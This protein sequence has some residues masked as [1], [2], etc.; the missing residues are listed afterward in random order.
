MEHAVEKIETVDPAMLKGISVKIKEVEDVGLVYFVE[1]PI[2]GVIITFIIKEDSVMNQPEISYKVEKALEDLPN[3]RYR[4]YSF[5]YAQEELEKGNLYFIKNCGLGRLIYNSSTSEKTLC[6]KKEKIELLL[7]KATSYLE[8]EID[9]INSFTEGISFYRKRKEWAGAAFLIHQKIEWLYRCL[10]TFAMG[11]PLICH[12]IKNHIGYA[13]PFIFGAGPIFN[14]ARRDDLQLLEVLDRA[15]TESRYHSAYD[16]TKREIKR[17]AERAEMMEHQ[18]R[19]I[20]SFRYGSC[21]KLLAKE[22]V[23]I[24]ETIPEVQVDSTKEVETEIKGKQ[25]L[26]EKIGDRLVMLKPHDTYKGKY[27]V[28]LL[29]MEGYGELLF[30]IRSLLYL[31]INSLEYGDFKTN[32][33]DRNPKNNIQ[34]V[35]EQIS[36]MIPIEEGD[37]LDELRGIENGES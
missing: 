31:C 22:K 2:E 15:Y 21:Q 8:R 19:E 34:D 37:L 3:L 25:I 12:K 24:F 26:A 18:V 14:T 9:R 1:D 32:S 30:T 36:R 35:L 10:E 11:K 27:K 23:N 29:Y 5:T 20:F 17:L 28:D 16:V 6:R 33:P 4:I 7:K 13:H